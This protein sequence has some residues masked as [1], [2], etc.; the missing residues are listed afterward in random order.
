MTTDSAIHHFSKDGSST[1][2]SN[3]F[4]QFYHNP[5]GAVSESNHVFFDVPN[6]DE[7]LK[8]EQDSLT[9]FE[10]G[11]GTGLNLLLLMDRY[12]K[13]TLNIP[14]HFYSVEAFPVGQEVA[15]N[16]NFGKFL[17]HPELQ[18]IIPDIFGKLEEG[19]NNFNPL[20]GKNIQ[21]HLFQGYFDELTEIEHKADFIFH[22][23]FSPEVN[24]ELWTVHA[25][26]K[27]ASF[28]KPQ[29]VLATYCASSK[30]RAAM[31]KAGWKLAKAQGALGKREMTV[32]SLDEY[33][34]THLKRVNEAR[35]IERFDAGEFDERPTIEDP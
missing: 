3:Q 5:N 11:F 15:E 26:Q 20:P 12:L 24:P 18:Q 23:A 28:S 34:L 7:A 16:F 31:A 25:F 4:G 2:Y 13:L 29:A 1:L 19:M 35:L 17:A 8:R 21:V 10:V 14:I 6:V 33:Q 32:A 22:D 27:L 30:A 9:F